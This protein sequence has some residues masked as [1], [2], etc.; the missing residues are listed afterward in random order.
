[1]DNPEPT[2][3][4]L[5]QRIKDL[6]PNFA[7]LEAVEVERPQTGKESNEFLREIWAPKVFMSNGGYDRQKGMDLADRTGGLVSYGKSFLANVR[8]FFF[9][10]SFSECANDEGCSPICHTS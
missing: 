3:S 7:F 1:M 10:T 5:A 4:Y 2:F 9:L 8:L 6:Y